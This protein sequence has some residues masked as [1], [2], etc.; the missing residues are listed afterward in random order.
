MLWVCVFITKIYSCFLKIWDSQDMKVTSTFHAHNKAVK[1]I[2]L[3]N[4]TLF[5]G[6]A[7]AS[8]IVSI[9]YLPALGL[10]FFSDASFLQGRSFTIN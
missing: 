4:S 5:T 1:S 6:S 2:V 9:N 10:P 8:I 3:N 7:D